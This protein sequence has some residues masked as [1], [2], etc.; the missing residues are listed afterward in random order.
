MS[1]NNEEVIREMLMLLSDLAKTASDKRR[2]ND[3]IDMCDN[4]NHWW[5]FRFQ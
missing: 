4:P 5:V 2:V 1:N 3:I